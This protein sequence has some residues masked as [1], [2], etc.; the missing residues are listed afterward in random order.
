MVLW[1]VSI[2]SEKMID[3]INRRC[4]FHSKGNTIC[5][6]CQFWHYFGCIPY[7]ERIGKVNT[8]FIDEIYYWRSYPT[9]SVKEEEELSRDYIFI[10]P[11]RFLEI[12]Q[13]KFPIGYFDTF[14]QEIKKDEVLREIYNDFLGLVDDDYVWL[15][16]IISVT[17]YDKIPETEVWEYLALPR[18][19]W[20]NYIG[21]EKLV[22]E[23]DNSERKG[24]GDRDVLVFR[25]L[26][27]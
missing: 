22:K 17:V 4:K 16:L 5:T 12:I 10:E 3:R 9:L 1:E 15:A 18:N 25:R 2:I 27:S 14:K 24:L 11:S 26:N 19:W 20:S 8:E 13:R 7:S 23:L 21:L 6:I